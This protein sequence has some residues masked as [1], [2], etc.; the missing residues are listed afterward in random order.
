ML[1]IDAQ[2]R[3]FT[4]P[5]AAMSEFREHAPAIAGAGIYSA[6]ILQRQVLVPVL[7]GHWRLDRL[8]G[9]SAE[10]EVARRRTLRFLERL[11]AASTA[12]PGRHRSPL[13]LA[14]TL[15]RRPLRCDS[16]GPAR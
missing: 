15:G 1:A 7:F 9:L 5:G 3:H 10:A 14:D 16:A 4:M 11:A 8:Q 6:S 13:T 12:C 2:T